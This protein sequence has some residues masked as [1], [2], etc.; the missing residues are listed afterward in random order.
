MRRSTLR[1]S[2][3]GRPEIDTVKVC[4]TADR[5]AALEVV[6]QVFLD[7]KRWIDQPEGEIPAV[8]AVGDP[9]SWFVARVGGE[10]A[11][12]IRLVY[13]PPLELPQDFGMTLEAGLDVDVLRSQGRFVEI[14]RFM[15]LPAHRRRFRVAI[16]LMKCAIR[17]VVERGYTHL[18]TDV[19][20]NDP[21]SP[22]HFHTRVL[23]FQRIGTHRHGEL[24]CASLRIILLLDIARTYHRLKRTPNK[25]FRELGTA[26]SEIL[27]ARLARS[28]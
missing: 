19:F 20:E 9:R 24:H 18:I 1:R 23:G 25:I 7:E 13:D 14:G 11:G 3:Q 8:L 15:I 22:L 5:A 2:I 17:E 28:A 4:T 12:L 26:V 27:E 10:P 6:R 16:A 21:H